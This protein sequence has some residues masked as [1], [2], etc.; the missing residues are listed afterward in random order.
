ML[1]LEN[2]THPLPAFLPANARLLML[3]SF[4]PP[5]FR[6]SMDFY[7]PNLNNDMYRIIGLVFFNNKDYFLYKKVFDKEKII[8]F[9]NKK[10][11][12]LSDMALVVKRL[13]NNASDKFLE[14]IQT[15]DIKYLLAQLPMCQ[16]IVVTGQKAA[17]LFL[18][19]FDTKEPK[20]GEFSE[21]IFENRLLR[22]YKMPSSSRAYPLSI[23]KKAKIY[24]GMFKDLQFLE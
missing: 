1:D 3:G 9:L 8:Y 6:W 21:F 19:Q 4:P 23:D 20:I 11:I 18:S 10:G 24:Y 2:E 15:N 17:L 22:F 12:A 16:S 13:K 14:M 7:Y 5:K